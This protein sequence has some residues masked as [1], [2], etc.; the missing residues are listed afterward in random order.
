MNNGQFA[1]KNLDSSEK[2]GLG[3]ANAVR[4]YPGGEAFGD[5]GY[6]LNLELRQPLPKWW[7][8][9]PGQMQLSGFIDT[10]TV[11]LNKS[12]IVTGNNRRTLSGIGLG[13]TWDDPGS[14]SVRM[15]YATKVGNAVATSIPDS[16]SRVWLQA[17]KYFYNVGV[18]P[19]DQR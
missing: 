15:F 7:D 4:A 14:F 16:P 11:T 8:S 18:R 10:G 5:Q 13:L 1:G 9:Q 2:F 6:V 17:V 3:G 19:G 12:P